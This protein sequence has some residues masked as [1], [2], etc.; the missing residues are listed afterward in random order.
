[1][2][3]GQLLPVDGSRRWLKSFRSIQAAS[4]GR[5]RVSTH[6]Q[7]VGAKLRL[8]LPCAYAAQVTV[9]SRRH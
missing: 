8:T 1:M 6:R 2:P 5:G 3:A 4:R 7:A 9:T